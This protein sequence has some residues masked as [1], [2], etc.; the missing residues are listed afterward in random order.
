VSGSL[1]KKFKHDYFILN[2]NDAMFCAGQHTINS[3]S[4]NILTN[5]LNL[6][7]IDVGGDE[8]T[9]KKNWMKCKMI[10]NFNK[11]W[12]TYKLTHLFHFFGRF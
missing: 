11:R 7:I 6:E 10:Y 1:L 8:E 3:V 4:F 9:M 12:K 5:A 2:Y